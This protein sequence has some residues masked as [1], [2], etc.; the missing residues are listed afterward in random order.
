MQD[1]TS[2]SI[3]DERAVMSEVRPHLNTFLL[4]RPLRSLIDGERQDQGTQ[5]QAPSFRTFH[6]FQLAQGEA[7]FSKGH[8]EP[9]LW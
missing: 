3:K 9:T 2:E 8:C 7:W 4:D 5:E 6:G 1:R